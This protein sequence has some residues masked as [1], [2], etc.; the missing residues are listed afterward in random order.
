MLYPD[1]YLVP[2]L[3]DEAGKGNEDKKVFKSIVSSFHQYYEARFDREFS[4]FKRS[5][6]SPERMSVYVQAVNAT[7]D[8]RSVPL[9][10]YKQKTRNMFERRLDELD[11][12]R[13]FLRKPKAKKAFEDA[14]KKHHIII[15]ALYVHMISAF[16]NE[17]AFLAS[18]I[19][20]SEETL[21]R[22]VDEKRLEVVHKRNVAPMLVERLRSGHVQRII[23][24]GVTSKLDMSDLQLRERAEMA[25]GTALTE[26][27]FA[28]LARSFTKKG[29]GFLDVV[30]LS[31]FMV[32][33]FLWFFRNVVYFY[34]Q[35][36]KEIS[37][38]LSAHSENL[39][40]SSLSTRNPEVAQK[41]AKWAKKLNALSDKFRIRM[42]DEDKSI[43]TSFGKESDRVVKDMAPVAQGEDDLI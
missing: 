4:E 21:G 42:D 28:Q 30:L 25:M 7:K 29:K 3:E 22:V 34:Y 38:F 33:L 39:S 8:M 5:G 18:C 32:L 2:V 35:A 40:Y 14:F 36:R 17:T 6:G 15:K 9:Q 20:V 41:Q 19:S 10:G 43:R 16:I 11:I 13:E 24:P 23:A 26:M 12:I 31:S 27:G 37:E 1:K